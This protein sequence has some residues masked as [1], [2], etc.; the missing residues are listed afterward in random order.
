VGFSGVPS[1]PSLLATGPLTSSHQPPSPP[2]EDVEEK[3]DSLLQ[4][5]YQDLQEDGGGGIMF[6]GCSGMAAFDGDDEWLYGGNDELDGLMMP[7]TCTR[8]ISGLSVAS[9]HGLTAVLEADDSAEEWEHSIARVEGWLDNKTDDECGRDIGEVSKLV[10]VGPWAGIMASL[11]APRTSAMDWSSYVAQ[12]TGSSGASS[13][14]GV[15][16]IPRLSREILIEGMGPSMAEIKKQK[17]ARYLEKRKRRLQKRK[18]TVATQVT[19]TARREI[20]NKRARNN[21]RFVSTSEFGP[22]SNRRR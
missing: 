16:V 19:Y 8:S 17:I 13:A 11:P 15:F 3:D 12:G 9:E 2:L 22:A 20:A 14:S 6:D 18:K 21:G 5:L 4:F 7:A 10:T 1:K